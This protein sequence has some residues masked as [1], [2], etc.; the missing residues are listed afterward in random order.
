MEWR[1]CNVPRDCDSCCVFIGTATNV[2]FGTNV[3][4]R[5][6][7]NLKLKWCGSKFYSRRY[8]DGRVRV[9]V[10]WTPWG[11]L[12]GVTET[13]F[14]LVSEHLEIYSSAGVYSTFLCIYYI[15]IGGDPFISHGDIAMGVCYEKPYI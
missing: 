11:R 5:P 10:E 6:I 14:V 12:H 9:A 2:S 8:R 7:Y 13:A 1:Y 15:L 3:A 4:H